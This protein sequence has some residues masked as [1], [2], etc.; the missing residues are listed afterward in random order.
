VRGCR[1]AWWLAD[2][3]DGVDDLVVWSFGRL[4]VWSFGRLVVWIVDIGLVGWLVGLVG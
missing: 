1:I 3:V 4:V 2:G